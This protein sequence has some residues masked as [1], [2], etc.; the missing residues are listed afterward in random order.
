MLLARAFLLLLLL[1]PQTDPVVEAVLRESRENSRVM[2]HLDHLC[3]R[4]G[5]RLTGSTNLVKACDWTRDEFARYGLEARL[6]PWGQFAVGFDRGPGSARMVEPEEMPLT[7]GTPAWSP[8]T[9]G[10]VTAPAVLAP[11]TDAELA[12]V[13]DRLRGAWVV[14]SARGPDPFASAYDEAGI[15]GLIR[16]A[17]RELIVTS[18]R[19][20]GSWEAIPTRVHV[21]MIASHH[22]KI[23]GLLKE[24]RAVRLRIDLRNT[25]VKGPIPLHNVIAD[26]RGTEKP[27]EM[28]IVGAH[29]DSWDG[30]QGAT[31]NGTGVASTL[32]AARLLTRAGAKPRRTIRFML[33][34]G[35]EQGLLGSRAWIRAN[36][37]ALPR[38][39]AVVVHDY[40]TN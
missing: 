37:D 5:P 27:E 23:V 35:E 29:L 24:G 28:V 2:A 16:S 20:P 34:T 33:F 19:P 30:A 15:A 26:L 21:T 40:G 38:I 13:K 25:F 6:E 39:S 1:P 7:V 9:D 32:E 8:G 17:P 22:A 14:S 4:I 3:H 36:P 18:G 11:T 12:A 10:P 31:D